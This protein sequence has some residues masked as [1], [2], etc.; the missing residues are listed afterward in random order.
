MSRRDLVAYSCAR[1][2]F[3]VASLISSP[4]S[5]V[6]F[7][8]SS[9]HSSR[10]WLGAECRGG[11]ARAKVIIGWNDAAGA[12]R[13]VVLFPADAA[14]AFPRPVRAPAQRRQ[15]G[16]RRVDDAAGIAA[17]ARGPHKAGRVERKGGE[18]GKLVISC[19][20]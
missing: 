18:G 8:T 11:F 4:T 9:N 16:A 5:R 10:K 2:F 12:R 19:C 1:P 15:E 17:Q 3:V 14:G 7:S 20:R 6:A 13:G